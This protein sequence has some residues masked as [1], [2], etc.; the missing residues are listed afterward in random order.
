MP[1]VFT[2]EDAGGAMGKDFTQEGTRKMAVDVRSMARSAMKNEEAR[3]REERARKAVAGAWVGGHG[4]KRRVE[5]MDPS[6]SGETDGREESGAGDEEGNGMDVDATP[7]VDAE[8][9]ASEDANADIAMAA[10]AAT[11]A[12]LETAA[13]DTGAEAAATATTE[14]EETVA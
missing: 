2:P 10:D 6:L 5:V 11:G 13:A 3:A 1:D 8:P 12:D 9:D 7:G 4:G 14:E